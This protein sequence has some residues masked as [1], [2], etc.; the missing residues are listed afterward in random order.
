ML[1]YVRLHVCMGISVCLYIHEHPCMH[2]MHSTNVRKRGQ[3]LKL[4]HVSQESQ[5]I[6]VS[7][8]DSPSVNTDPF[9]ILQ[10]SPSKQIT[11]YKMKQYISNYVTD[12]K[13]IYT[14][15]KTVI[16]GMFS[17]AIMSSYF[18]SSILENF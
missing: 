4:Y 16:V 7:R 6:E 3:M 5:A 10:P 2:V 11:A 18:T 9:L 8:S 12:F 13:L 15:R 1:I 17:R 14:I